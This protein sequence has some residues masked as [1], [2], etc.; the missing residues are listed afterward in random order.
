MA[1][2]P[3]HL[4]HRRLELPSDRPLRVPAR[5]SVRASRRRFHRSRKTDLLGSQPALRRLFHLS[6]LL[7]QKAR[8]RF[9]PYESA[10]GCPE[11]LPEIRTR[12]RRRLLRLA[13]KLS[14]HP[15]DFQRK[16]KLIEPGQPLRYRLGRRPRHPR[17]PRPPFRSL[18]P[19]LLGED[20]GHHLTFEAQGIRLK[21]GA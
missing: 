10:L 3:F 18:G 2:R 20:L 5:A 8:P 17:P 6:K 7:Q 9:R 12:Y 1:P 15:L 14:G 13:K 21:S 16:P 11:A 19:G 4:P